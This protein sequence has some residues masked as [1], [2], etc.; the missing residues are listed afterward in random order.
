MN[1]KLSYFERKAV[2]SLFERVY[3]QGDFAKPKD[4]TG[5]YPRLFTLV[6]LH[7]PFLALSA[8]ERCDMTKLLN[9]VWGKVR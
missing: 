9:V 3:F 1:S 5:Y 4:V 8:G 6:K 7:H 2:L